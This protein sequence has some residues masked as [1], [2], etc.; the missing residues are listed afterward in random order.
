MRSY[1]IKYGFYL[2][3]FDSYFN[4]RATKYIVDN[5]LDAYWK[6]HDTMSWYPEGR[7]IAATSQPGLHM[8]AAFLY[9]IFGRSSGVSLLDFSII[10]PVI[11]GSLT[12]IVVFV[13][14]RTIVA[15]G[16]GSSSTTAGM[17]AALLFSFSPPLIFRGN[18]GWFKSEPL[19]LFLGLLAVYLFLSAFK[20]KN[21]SDDNNNNN[22]T[23]QKIK[24]LLILKALAG[25]IILGLGNASWN[26][27]QYF[28]IPISFFLIALPFIRKKTTQSQ[29]YVAIVF[30]VFAIV[31]T[32]A[33]P[34]TGSSF[35]LSVPSITLV[36]ATIFFVI[37]NFI[38]KKYS[39]N[40]RVVK[41]NT[42]FVLIALILLAI[43]I[44][45]IAG[46]LHYLPDI[47]YLEIVNP[48]AS[49]YNP[50]TESVAENVPPSIT[51]YLLSFSTLLIF[52]GIGIWVALKRRDEMS[53]FALLI[54][55][56][57][58]YVSIE[59]LRLL[60]FASV[61]IVILAAIGLQ[62]VTRS[63]METSS[64]NINSSKKTLPSTAAATTTTT[65]AS[66][67]IK[68]KETKKSKQS[69]FESDRG[70][71][72]KIGCICFVILLLLFP[73]FYPRNM[74]W[75][76]YADILPTIINGGIGD[77]V[78]NY[79]WINALNWISKNT[80]K[81]AVIAAW[82]DYG[83]WITTLA[84]R[85]T[86]VDNAANIQTRIAKVAQMFIESPEEGIKIA[87]KLKAN[88]IL[89]YS[90]SK[91]ITQINNSSY[92]YISYQGG[93]ES[94]LYW[95]LRIGGFKVNDYLEDDEYTPKPKFWN[96][97]L[98]GNLLPFTLQGYTSSFGNGL[99]SK[100]ITNNTTTAIIFHKYK[101]GAIALYSK[102]IK[103]PESG[104]NQD[105]LKQPLTLV[106]SSSDSSFNERNNQEGIRPSV[107]VFKVDNITH[108][109]K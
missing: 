25:G 9:E 34:R 90:V 16:G 102:Q 46:G 11:I 56:T 74:N 48:F 3:E 79:D 71:I 80:P 52:G 19:G 98:I 73:M 85:T 18:L 44:R 67:T 81:N 60:V 50:F 35:V 8:V 30:T 83:Y 6:W 39:S 13:L 23:N 70:T 29:M 24:Y 89:V 64:S 33:F 45:V 17:F 20:H 37:S 32:A 65:T 103:Y 42:I 77:S 1:P 26:G 22:A 7:D 49:S 36:G 63:I 58:L 61:G 54:A 53:V 68:A 107:L 27:V 91:I 14:L 94:K 12:T 92:Y 2:N 47:K 86:L 69:K 101:L 38:K 82:W 21:N 43:G 78:K 93:D 105:L 108:Y 95:F 55:I 99:D 88:Y 28:I 31:I 100:I 104:K 41:R 4:Y 106:Y 84:N 109:T 97:T 59:S 76:S 15:S 62:W 57:G 96:S 75:I 87:N 5:G 40:P 51:D 72:V 66:N 10:F